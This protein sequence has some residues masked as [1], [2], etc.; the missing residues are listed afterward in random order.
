MFKMLSI[1]VKLIL[2]IILIFIASG[3]LIHTALENRAAKLRLENQI[4]ESQ[5]QL[6]E[7]RIKREQEAKIAAEE[8]RVQEEKRL[9]IETKINSAVEAY[10]AR[11]Y[12]EA[13][14]ISD[15]VLEED[16][17]NYVAYNIKG[18]ALSYSNKYDEGM[19]NINKALEI[20][21][22][23]GFGRYSKALVYSHFR[24][25]D[26]ALKW[27]DKALEVEDY[28]WSHYGKAV[29]F[30]RRGDGAGAAASLKLAME[31][32]PGLRDI[33]IENRDKDFININNSVEFL[34]IIE[35]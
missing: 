16:E 14:N 15:E 34:E 25:N 5:Q 24:H 29:I 11:R 8:K 10:G 31:L 21:P 33:I 17:E 12:R 6:E 4:K 30:A 27:Y 32:D 1:K 23:Y 35:E 28:K 7:A 13:I 26:E 19:A 2:F 18:L 9:A 20:N 3:V 22:D